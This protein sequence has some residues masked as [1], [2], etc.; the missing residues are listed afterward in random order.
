MQLSNFKLTERTGTDAL[1][2]KF[3]AV[4]TMETG[5]WFMKKTKD[6]EIYKEYAS[7]WCFTETGKF[8]PM[9]YAEVA[10]RKF[11]ASTICEIETCAI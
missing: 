6:V 4:V 11:E 9:D 7:Y 5:F 3:K 10:Q 8:T 2:W 1:S